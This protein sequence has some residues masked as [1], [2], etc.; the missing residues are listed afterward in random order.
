MLGK[1]TYDPYV[2]DIALSVNQDTFLVS[3]VLNQLQKFYNGTDTR[4]MVLNAFTGSG[5]TTVTIKRTIP[6]FIKEFYPQGKRVIGFI[7]PRDEVAKLK[8]H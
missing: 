2:M 5:K 1:T 3:Q 4:K 6:D 8:N 7:C